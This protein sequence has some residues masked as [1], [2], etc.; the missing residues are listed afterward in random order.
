MHRSPRCRRMTCVRCWSCLPS[1][2]VLSGGFL[3]HCHRMCYALPRP[4]VFSVVPSAAIVAS[5]CLRPSRLRQNSPPKCEHSSSF[6]CAQTRAASPPSLDLHYARALGKATYSLPPLRSPPRT[7]GGLR[8][9]GF[10]RS[11]DCYGQIQ[12]RVVQA[13]QRGLKATA[14]ARQGSAV[15]VQ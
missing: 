15:E 8:C 6:P 11:C 4:S 5:A 7:G 9:V 13:W 14:R 3:H 1:M 2:F 10:P 12:M